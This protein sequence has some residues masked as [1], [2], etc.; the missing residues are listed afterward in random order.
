MKVGMITEKIS[1]TE[2]QAKGFWPIYNRFD[3]EKRQ[4]NQ[5]IREQMR[6]EARGSEQAEIAR[7]DAIF[8]LRQQEV[9]LAKKYRPEFLKVISAS[10]Y[11]DLLLA[12][13]EFNQMLLR[14]LR[15]RRNSRN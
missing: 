9:E 15:E 8:K 12:E 1:L 2:E 14:E 4:V 13:K 3:A 7:Q 6:A 5:T 11:S 10:Q